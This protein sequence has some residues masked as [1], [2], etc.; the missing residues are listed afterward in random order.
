MSDKHCS[1]KIKIFAHLCTAEKY[2]KCM[3]I[4]LSKEFAINK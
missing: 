3:S 2:E 1:F 4:A